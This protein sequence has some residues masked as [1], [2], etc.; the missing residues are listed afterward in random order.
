MGGAGAVL[1]FLFV[2]LRICTPCLVL[3]NVLS[4]VDVDPVSIFFKLKLYVEI[5]MISI[6][7]TYRKR[8]SLVAHVEDWLEP[9]YPFVV[10]SSFAE[11]HLVVAEEFVVAWHLAIV[12]L[13]LQ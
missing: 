2:V 6:N 10:F 11:S 9:A 7:N 8:V 4:F 3:E 1:P 12:S 13:R 5:F